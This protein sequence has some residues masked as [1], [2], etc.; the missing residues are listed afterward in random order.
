MNAPIGSCAPKNPELSKIYFF[1]LAEKETR[2]V[3]IEKHIA[4][5]KKLLSELERICAEGES[6][7]VE[8]RN[9]DIFRYQLQTAHYGRDLTKF[10]IEWYAAL[11]KEI[12]E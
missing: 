5:L 2:I 11:L 3:S 9:N 4:E 6:L 12:K 1:G 10:N 8:N 7:S